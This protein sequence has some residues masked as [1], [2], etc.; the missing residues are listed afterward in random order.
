MKKIHTNFNI[1]VGVNSAILVGATLGK[2]SP[3]ATGM[4]HNGTTVGLLLNALN[5][6]KG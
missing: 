6:V 1:T 2:L 4:L 3:L 5:P